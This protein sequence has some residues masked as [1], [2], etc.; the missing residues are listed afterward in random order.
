MEFEWDPAKDRSNQGKHGLSF[1]EAQ[2]LFRS[3]GDR[4]R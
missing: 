2:G 1:T 4:F 3:H